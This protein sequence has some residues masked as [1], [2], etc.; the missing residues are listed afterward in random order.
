MQL[1][2]RT[3]HDAAQVILTEGF[4]DGRGRYMTDIE[5]SGVWLADRPLDENE[6]AE[7]DTLLSV[8]LEQALAEQYEWVEDRKP[9]REFCVP[10]VVVN[11]RAV[12]SVYVEDD[13]WMGIPE[14]RLD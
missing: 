1:Y 9:Y 7:G 12:V 4:R 13:E 3:N 2:H 6:G 14:P 8:E 5:F 11:Q 10:A